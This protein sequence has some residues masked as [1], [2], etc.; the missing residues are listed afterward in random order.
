MSAST[1]RMRLHFQVICPVA[2]KKEQ[3]GCL[4]QLMYFCRCFEPLC[5]AMALLFEGDASVT[6][7]NG[8]SFA[9]LR[10]ASWLATCPALLC[11]LFSMPLT[12][13]SQNPR[14]LL[15]ALLLDQLMVLLGVSSVFYTGSSKTILFVM[16][17]LC[18]VA[19]LYLGYRNYERSAKSYEVEGVP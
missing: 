15:A 13:R 10:Y 19:L 18:G 8:G 16:A 12:T 17:V 5:Y 6:L 7:S 3:I 4:I 2:A 11:S 9:W 14:E 1:L